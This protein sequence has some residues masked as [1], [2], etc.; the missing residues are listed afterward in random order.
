MKKRTCSKLFAGLLASAFLMGSAF[1][2]GNVTTRT[3]QA[4]YSGIRLVVDGVEVTPADASGNV[5][6]PF[7]IDGTT[8]LPVRAV[9]NALGK[10]VDWEGETKTVYI[11]EK[12]S[13]AAPWLKPHLTDHATVYDGSDLQK[14]FTV[15][16]AKHTDGFT[17]ESYRYWWNA[18]D[19][20]DGS[21]V[22]ATNSQYKSM[23]FTVG[24]TGNAQ[25]N[26]CLKV[27]FD[28]VYAET[29][30]LPGW[31]GAPKTITIQL[32]YAPNVKLELVADALPD[33]SS[34]TPVYGFY[35]V[36]FAQ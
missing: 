9:A 28:G 18:R 20:W 31:D 10:A 32:D 33:T 23:T 3:V 4:I 25:L 30:E 5:V 29:Y 36:S 6:E 35:D 26:A 7:I 14:F 17:M 12:P 34:R 24:H 19:C 8:Y 15:A 21:A 27:Y 11:G 2:A 16:G 13:Q 1:A 22:W